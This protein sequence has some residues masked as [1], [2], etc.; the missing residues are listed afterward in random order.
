MNL[1]ENDLGGMELSAQI[2]LC[3]LPLSLCLGGRADSGAQAS[4]GVYSALTRRALGL[5][6]GDV[7]ALIKHC[8]T[9]K[10]KTNI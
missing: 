4:A 5:S 9:D 1:L 2:L 6:R 3:L 8:Q 10:N 7:N